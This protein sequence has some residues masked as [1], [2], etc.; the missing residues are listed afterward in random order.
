MP[1]PVSMTSNLSPPAVPGELTRTTTSPA[2]VNLMALPARLIST[3]RRRMGSPRTAAGTAGSSSQRSSSPLARARTPKISIVSS[4]ISRRAKSIC[5]SSSLP[6]SIFEKSRMSLMICSRPS[7]ERVMVSARRRWRGESSV[8]CRSS[9]IPITPFI[10]VRISWL[11]RARNSLFAE[12]ARSA[13]S[14]AAVASA[15]ACLSS[16]LALPR[17]TV[18]SATCCSRNCR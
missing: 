3:C 13:A 10:G 15:M 4:M 11:M 18:R 9:D 7:A 2:S 1:I 6:A 5:S 16:R 8:P 14:F 12:L 17:F